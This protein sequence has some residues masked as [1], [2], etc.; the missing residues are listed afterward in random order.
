[1]QVRDSRCR[2]S[3]R[4]FRCRTT[5]RPG[6]AGLDLRA[7]LDA[8]LVLE[9]GR[10]AADTHRHRDSPR[11]SGPGRRAAAALGSRPQA[12]HR[13][14]Q[15]GRPDR[16]GL[17]GAGDGV[18][19]ESRP[20]APS[21]SNRASASRRWSSCPVVQVDVRGRRGRSRERA[22]SRRVRQLREGAE[23]TAEAGERPPMDLPGL[24]VDALQFL[25]A[26]DIRANSCV[27]R[28]RVP[29]CSW[30]VPA[31]RPAGPSRCLRSPLRLCGQHR[32]VRFGLYG[33]NRCTRFINRASRRAGSR[34]TDASRV[35]CSSSP[36][37][38][39]AQPL[40]VRDR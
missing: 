40:D 31:R 18:V 24:D 37:A 16:L 12:R 32:R 39:V 30:S 29:S 15:P 17:P 10:H 3:A 14:R 13:A 5:R 19:L 28:V 2:A 4:N 26:F 33:R 20:D 22:R 11:R 38:L 23:A 21:R 25:E 8:P 7:C 34:C 9:P 36:S 1:M 27:S 35:C 6:S